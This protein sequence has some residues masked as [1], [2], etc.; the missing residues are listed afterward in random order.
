M[1][2]IVILLGVIILV[3]SVG[4]FAGSNDITKDIVDFVENKG[5]SVSD[6][7]ISEVN[8]S[9]L[10]SGVD[11]EKIE[12]S[13]V[14]IYEVD[15]GARPL[16]VVSSGSKKV[17]PSVPEYRYRSLLNFGFN[18]KMSSSGFLNMGDVEGGIEKGY[19]M[20]RSGSIS[21]I[22]S[23]LNVVDGKEME[24]IEVRIYKDGKIIGLRNG[25]SADKEGSFVDY[26]SLSEGIVKFDAGDVI[27][28]Y[29]NFGDGV[30]VADV[31][32]V[33]EIVS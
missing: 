5:I 7:N 25:L 6:S 2:K 24:D 26:D 14:V 1:E 3:L 32:T 31:V 13:S 33:L 20:M 28:V 23:I 19:V 10:P 4:V 29:V 22:S 21:G 16:F 11:I 30:S 17:V 18:G 15:Y 27:S 8:F 9:D 12:N